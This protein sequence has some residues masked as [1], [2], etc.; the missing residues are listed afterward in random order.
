MVDSESSYVETGAISGT[1][2]FVQVFMVDHTPYTF[3]LAKQAYDD[4]GKPIEGQYVQPD[5]SISST[6]TRY[7]T[8]K[9]ALPTSFL[10]FNTHVSYRNWNLALS[11][12]GAFG[13]YIYNYVVADD[14][15]ESVYSDQGSYSNILRTTRDSGFNQQRLYTDHFL[16]K[17][18]FFRFDNITLGYT[19]HK[20]W[21][22]TSSLNLNLGIQNLATITN[23]TGVDPEMYSGIDR[24]V[25]QRPRI[26]TFGMNLTF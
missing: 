17:G 3:Y 11:G 2:K 13:N 23:Y 8:N 25:Y 6:E 15:K 26:Y 16:E 18:S 22:K 10:G 12:H 20:L 21:N 4:K 7:A 19:F 1:G 24:N 14:Y 9:S 5:G